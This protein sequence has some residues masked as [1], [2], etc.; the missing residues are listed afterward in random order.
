MQNAHALDY[1]HPSIKGDGAAMAQREIVRFVRGIRRPRSAAVTAAQIKKWFRATP[2]D[3]IERQI[4]AACNS[5]KIVI[6]QKSLSSGR[7]FNGAYVYEVARDEISP[8]RDSD[9]CSDCPPGRY[10]T[11]KTRCKP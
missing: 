10:P 8:T 9:L 6:R 11:D 5:G 2:G 7:K 4:D 3:F 1:S